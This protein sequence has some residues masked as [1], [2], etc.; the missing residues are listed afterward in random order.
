MNKQDF[1]ENL[2]LRLCE[3]PSEE[4]LDRIDFY[5]EMIDDIIEDGATEEDAVAS[6]GTVDDI[7]TQIVSEIPL[8]KIAKNKLKK[9]RRMR[10]WEIVLLALGSPIWVSLLVS[11]FAVI[12]SLYVSLW[13]VVIS[14][15]AVFAAFVGCSI[16]GLAA[17]VLFIVLKNIWLGLGFISASLVLAGLAIFAFLDAWQRPKGV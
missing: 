10:V 13:T 2:Q 9:R 5:S 12:L 11:V 15:W 14:V 17:G 3:L 8:S 16:G 7:A 1:L 4:V 6:V